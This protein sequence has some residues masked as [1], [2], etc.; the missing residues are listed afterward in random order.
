VDGADFAPS[1]DSF[2]AFQRIC[3]G[4]NETLGGWQ[5]LKNKDVAALNSLLGQSKIGTLPNYP[6][7]AADSACTE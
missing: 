5:E 7:A 2:A 4:L 6:A 1:E 3:K